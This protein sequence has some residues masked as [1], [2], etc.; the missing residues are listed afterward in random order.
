MYGLGVILYELCTGLHPA[1]G[2]LMTP[3]E[4][5]NNHLLARVPPLVTM[6]TPERPIPANLSALCERMMAKKPDGPCTMS[7]AAEG[8]ALVQSGLRAPLR[9]AARNMGEMERPVPLAKTEPAMAAS[10]PTGT[11]VMPAVPDAAAAVGPAERVEAV[12]V[13]TPP[14]APAV[15][16]AARAGGAARAAALAFRR[17]SGPGASA[18]RL[19]VER[20]S[21]GAA[22]AARPCSVTRAAGDA[23]DGRRR[24]GAR[25]R[26]DGVEAHRMRGSHGGAGAA[27]SG[28]PSRDGIRDGAA[29]RGQRRAGAAPAGARRVGAGASA[30]R[31]ARA[32]VPVMC[33]AGVEPVLSRWR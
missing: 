28:S 18:G 21:S 24:A 3:I 12:R 16:L 26:G 20:G 22:R 6:S 15:D 33:G 2:P 23:R 7:E 32:A 30:T 19:A 29:T 1:A 9:A 27:L 25:A 11:I 17:G 4:V 5:I 8:L 10:G 14:P 31:A 13:A